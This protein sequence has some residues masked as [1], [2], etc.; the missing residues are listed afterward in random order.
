[1]SLKHGEGELVVPGR[2]E[3]GG[4]NRII[5]G[6][7]LMGDRSGTLSVASTRFGDPAPAS[8][9]CG[10][11]FKARPALGSSSGAFGRLGGFS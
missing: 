2:W 3:M 9:S 1:M 5:G 6:R 4:V 11:K 7:Q 10:V 8:M